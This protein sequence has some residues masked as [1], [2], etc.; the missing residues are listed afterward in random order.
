MVVI[1]L[2]P[3]I[4]PLMFIAGIMGML[5]IDIK[6]STAMVFTIAFGIA[7]DDTIHFISKLKIELA[8][9]KTL[10]YAIKRTY[11]STGKAIILTSIILSGGFL[12]LIFS[13]FNGT[14][15]LGLMVGMALIFAVICDLL[16][17]PIL[18]IYFYGK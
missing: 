2:I 5:S 3:N 18:I 15:Y 4:L 7:V 13:D 16:L 6:V 9:G 8:K 14:F 11:L 12:T 10:L 17:L 1:S